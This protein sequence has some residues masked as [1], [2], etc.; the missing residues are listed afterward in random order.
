MNTKKIYVVGNSREYSRWI[1][2]HEL[3]DN[4]ADADIVLFTGGEDVDPSLYGKQKHHTTYSNIHRDLQEK[5]IFDQVKPNQLCLGICRGSQFLCVMNKGILVQNVNNHAT[6]GTHQIYD[7][8]GN[9]YEITS[10]HHQMQY[11]FLLP[12]T[13]YTVLYHAGNRADYY[14]GD[15]VNYPPCDPEIVLYKT[16]GLPKCLAIQGHPEMMRNEAP[17]ID[18][19][20]K[21]IDK[22]VG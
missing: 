20:N 9:V 6:F 19:L 10:T 15:G 12:E 2:N 17:V 21:L 3:V 13:N 5:E 14:E 11:P 18:M 4:L 8:L 22:Y 1:K 7:R 16:P